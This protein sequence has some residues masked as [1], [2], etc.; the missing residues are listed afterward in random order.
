MEPLDFLK[1][2]LQTHRPVKWSNFPD[3]SLYMDQVISYMPRQFI[4]IGLDNELT[5]AMVN[6]YIK[7][8]LLPRAEGKK[9]TRIHLSYLTMIC[10]LK[11]VLSV[12]EIKFLLEEIGSDGEAEKLYEGFCNAL[13]IALTETADVLPD[14]LLKEDLSQ[15]ALNFAL[16]SYA[17][18]LVCTCILNALKPPKASN[19]KDKGKK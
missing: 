16:R 14:S 17:D 2:A 18:R 3:I 5:P 4:D 6:N 12:K 10:A 7:D 19:E 1:Q 15:T 11:Q 9:Y 13:D 8:G